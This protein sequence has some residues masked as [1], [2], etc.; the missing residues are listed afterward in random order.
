VEAFWESF[1]LDPRQPGHASMRASDADREIVRVMLADAYADG[2]LTREEYDDRLN[3]LYGS[4]T[5]GEMPA[6]VTDLV[7]PDGPAMAP[8][9]LPPADLRTRGARKWRRDVEESIGALLFPSVICTVI[10]IA[11]GGGGFFWP[12]FPMLFL[13][14]NLI[15]TIVQRETVIER[16]VLRLQEQAAK[17]TAPELPAADSDPDEAGGSA[18]LPWRY[19]R[20]GR[21]AAGAAAAWHGAGLGA[22]LPVRGVRKRVP[23]FRVRAGLAG[24]GAASRSAGAPQARCRHP[25]PAGTGGAPVGVPRVRGAAPPAVPQPGLPPA[26]RADSPRAQKRW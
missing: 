12:A 19:D 1:R 21:P 7:P 26:F 22:G 15:K 23:A 25:G 11:V 3:T 9:T 17:D 4:R 14:L 5:L 13:G 6:L 2:R 20:M 24:A 10:W 18:V 16:E 8:A